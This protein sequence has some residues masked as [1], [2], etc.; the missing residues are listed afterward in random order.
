MGAPGQA[1]SGADEA[2]GEGHCVV[3]SAEIRRLNAI[4]NASFETVFAASKDSL[5]DSLLDSRNPSVLQALNEAVDDD[6]DDHDEGR[7]LCRNL[8]TGDVVDLRNNG[9]PQEAKHITPGDLYS[10]GDA[11][12]P[13]NSWRRSKRRAN[14]RLW[15]A[16]E[17]GDLSGL[18]KA[19]APGGR[20]VPS[21]VDSR[22]LN[23]WTALHLAAHAGHMD[24]VSE[25][26]RASADI[27][28]TT[29]GGLSSL[30]VAC[31]RGHLGVVQVLLGHGCD[32]GQQTAHGETALHLASAQ[33]HVAILQILLGRAGDQL[34]LVPNRFG[35][36]PSEVC[37]NIETDALFKADAAHRETFSVVSSESSHP[38]SEAFGKEDGYAGRTTYKG[39]VLLR[40]ARTDAVRKLLSLTMTT[41]PGPSNF[42]DRDDEESGAAS[43]FLRGGILNDRR[44]SFAKLRSGASGME[45]VGPSSFALQALLGKGSFGEVY[46]VAHKRT[47][48]VY[49]MK[50]LKKSRI[51]G[52][53][54]LR[55]A[56]TERNILSFVRHP[57]IIS[58]HWAFQTCSHLVLILQFCPGGNLQSLILREKKLREPLAQLY[59]A[60][61][62]LALEYLHQRSI[63]FRDLKPDNIVLDEKGHAML[64]DFGLSKEGVDS[65]ADGTKSFCGSVAYLAPEILR[66]KGHGQAV[67]LYGLGVLLFEMVTGGPPFFH[68]QRDI[69]FKNIDSAQLRVPAHVSSAASSL[70]HALMRR[71]PEQRIGAE[72]TC[73]VRKHRFFDG[74]DFD[75]VLRREVAAPPIAPMMPASLL[76]PYAAPPSPFEKHHKSEKAHARKHEV[77]GWEF[78]AVPPA[79][80]IL[81]GDQ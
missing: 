13:W 42:E 56:R 10:H 46:Q 26:L 1:N 51:I 6:D 40:N 69:L 48:E 4:F 59:A 22:S 57:F 75:K 17:T 24:V 38:R 32:V 78:A 60:E 53:N 8:D 25:L 73:E 62:L 63:V 27:E 70:I 3:P 49:A 16:A 80:P 7:F 45:R 79:E 33:G 64:T 43:C 76:V 61:I 29:Q 31:Q 2:A 11:A 23:G 55:Y 58:L 34:L 21:N 28:A 72:S 9:L 41:R 39:S 35:Q 71:D 44:Q 54:L 74:L 36:R 77:S 19:L 52:R 20:E 67:D 15:L 66:R 68:H 14:E 18:C 50:V 37:L 81:Q 12:T 30:H 65:F 5:K 47:Q